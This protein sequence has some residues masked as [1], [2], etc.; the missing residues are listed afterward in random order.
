MIQSLDR[1]L[2]LLD[3]ISQSEEGYICA[4]LARVISVDRST[5]YRLLETLASYNYVHQN[6]VTKKYTLGNKIQDLSLRLTSNVKLQNE[7]RTFLKLLTRETGETSH[8]AVLRD[9]EAVI[10]DQELSSAMIGIHTSI[11]MH[12]PLHSTALGKAICAWLSEQERMDV[13]KRKGLKRCTKNTITNKADFAKE[14]SQIK[15]QGYALDIEEYKEGIKC[16]ASPLFNHKGV[17][18]A[19]GISAPSERLPQE[20]VLPYSNIIKEASLSLSKRLGYAIR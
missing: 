11:G 2:K 18:A 15:Q 16:L 19:I 5:A 12:E 7:A 20:K 13:I 3:H 4:D 1:A 9:G 10:I 14:I 8:L 17:I 6:P